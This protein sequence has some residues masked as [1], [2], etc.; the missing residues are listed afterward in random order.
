LK[1][2]STQPAAAAKPIPEWVRDFAVAAGLALLV[3][4]VYWPVKSYDFLLFDDDE[5]VTNNP[6][7]QAGLTSDAIRWAFTSFEHAN[8]HPLTWLSHIL[9]CTLFGLDAGK[10]HAV[11][12]ALHIANSILLYG[13]LKR[14]THRF[15]RSAIV[16]AL[17]ALHPLHVESVAWVAERKDVLS[18]LFG[19]L[20][21]WAYSGYSRRHQSWRYVA[22]LMLFA[23]A[24]LAKPMMVTLPFVLLLLDY[25]PLRRL[26][27][28]QGIGFLQRLSPLLVEKIPLFALTSVSIVFTMKAQ[29]LGGAVH[30]LPFQVK[31]TNAALAYGE[32]LIKMLVPVRLAAFYPYRTDLLSW[33]SM[34]TALVVTGLLA[35]LIFAGRKRP[36]WIVGWAWY[37]GMLIPVIGFIQA[38]AQSM[39]DRYTYMPIVGIFIAVVWGAADFASRLQYGTKLLATVTAAALF[40]CTI[41]SAQQVTIWMNTET[42]FRHAL[43]V[44]SGDNHFAHAKLGEV[45]RQ[46]GDLAEAIREYQESLRLLPEQPTAVNYLGLALQLQGRTAEAIAQY[47]LSLQME[48]NQ[49]EVLNNL[50]WIRATHPD[51]RFRNGTEAVAMAQRAASIMNDNPQMLDTLA[52]SLAETGRFDEAVATQLQAIRGSTGSLAEKSIARMKERAELYKAGRAYRDV[53]LAR[54]DRRE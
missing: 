40:A 14:M 2:A 13:V 9:D 51:D 49:P 38:G 20:T 7:V 43:D 48:P 39:A 11:N 47:Q 45:A 8:W 23:A 5:Y 6:H 22:V 15:W 46:R 33:G 28:D 50:A 54:T 32:Y 1:S 34:T 12:V 41:L 42:L 17:F 29:A 10:H 21:C 4:I 16:A 52:A 35:G 30:E 3:F 53:T 26:A 36:Y 37:L 31:A 25:W 27:P 44:S 18:M 24:L 19:L